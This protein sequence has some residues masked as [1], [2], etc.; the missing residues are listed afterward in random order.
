MGNKRAITALHYHNNKGKKSRA[1]RNK[2]T[3]TTMPSK[4]VAEFA[5]E[6]YGLEFA[7]P[8]TLKTISWAESVETVWYLSLQA[9]V[10]T[11]LQR[12]RERSDQW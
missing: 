6:H 5:N 4:K 12:E 7:T 3:D 10:R 8:V 9:S 11:G 1:S 2:L